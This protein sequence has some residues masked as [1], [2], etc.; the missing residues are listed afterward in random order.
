MKITNLK[1][2]RFNYM[3]K[4]D[5]KIKT[6]TILTYKK[7]YN[8]YNII[9][10]PSDVIKNKQLKQG[11]YIYFENNN[12]I[13]TIY[14]K[15]FPYNII[16]KINSKYHKKYNYLTL[17]IPTKLLKT[18]KKQSKLILIEYPNKLILKHI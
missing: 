13:I 3:N 9:N 17:C 18:I 2:W 8:N 12:E 15:T 11:D 6:Y 1:K 5:N 10:I 7:N 14:F 4:T 16:R